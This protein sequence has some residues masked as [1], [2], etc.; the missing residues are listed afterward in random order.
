MINFLIGEI[1]DGIIFVIAMMI[2][3]VGVVLGSM[4]TVSL[5][6]AVGIAVIG[7]AFALVAQMLRG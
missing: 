6:V 7:V 4:G 2:I 5:L 1:V 3:G